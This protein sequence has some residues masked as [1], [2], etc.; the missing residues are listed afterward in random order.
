MKT[1]IIPKLKNA[2]RVENGYSQDFVENKLEN[3]ND[4]PY[5]SLKWRK[6]QLLVLPAGQQKQ[7][8]LPAFEQT[9]NLVECLKHSPVSI[10]RLDPRLGE[11]R[12]KIWTEACAQAGKPVYLNISRLERHFQ[13]PSH[14]SK[15]LQFLLE[16]MAAL[17]L[18]VP[19]SLVFLCLV[20]V[21]QIYS[22][23]KVFSTE[24]HVGKRGRIFQ[25]LKFHIKDENNS[26][27][28]TLHKLV[29]DNF[30]QLINV[31]RGEISLFGHRGWSLENAL[32]QNR[33]FLQS[34]ALFGTAS[35]W[36]VEPDTS[37]LQL[38]SQTL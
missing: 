11:Y 14:F 36:Q 37:I 8:N 15:P 6:G 16:W 26:P 4:S 34:K 35:K 19:L 12:I 23:G 22:P 38:D 9:G 24:W 30:P 29:L 7:P 25:L 1:S 31:L 17:T 33:E 18:S 5:C 27:I 21:M 32:E 13:S 28:W 10:V 3:S 2:P 20:V